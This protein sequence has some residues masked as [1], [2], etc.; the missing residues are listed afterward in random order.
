MASHQSTF[1]EVSWSGTSSNEEFS[2]SDQL[3]IR[4]AS[5]QEVSALLERKLDELPGERGWNDHAGDLSDRHLEISYADGGARF[6]IDFVLFQEGPDVDVRILH[7]G[8]RR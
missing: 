1:G 4:A 6:W 2:V 3:I 8:I 5:V 7:K